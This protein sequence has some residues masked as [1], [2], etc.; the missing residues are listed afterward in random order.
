ML[1]QRFQGSLSKMGLI[2][3]LCAAVSLSGC[4]VSWL[5][6]MDSILAS[7]APALVTILQIASI[8]KGQPVDMGLV[9][10]INGDAARVKSIAAD[11]AHASSA[12]APVICAQ[13]Q[14]ALGTYQADLPAVMQ[15]AHVENANTQAKIEELSVLI[16]GLF[17]SIEPL[18][19]AC[20]A[21]V[22]AAARLSSAPPIP[23]PVKNFVT[24]YNAILVAPTGLPAVDH[25]TPGLKLHKHS[26]YVRIL[27]AGRLK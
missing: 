5:T 10:K 27:T 13:L 11:F 15:V 18:I 6:T 7:A 4:S 14:A 25:A 2:A 3:L 21:P 12:A 1:N 9:T 20:K 22:L 23:L 8:A 17:T 26:K 24:A 16:V 19:P